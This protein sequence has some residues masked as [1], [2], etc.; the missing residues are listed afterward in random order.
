MLYNELYK[1]IISKE[2]SCD[3]LLVDTITNTVDEF[4]A[5]YEKAFRTIDVV[6]EAKAKE[7]V[8][9]FSKFLKTN[10]HLNIQCWEPNKEEYPA[11]MLLGADKGILAYLNFYYHEADYNTAI[12]YNLRRIVSQVKLVISDLDRPTFFVHV[13]YTPGI[14]GI[15]FETHEQ[16]IDRL[17]NEKESVV[18]KDKY[19]CQPKYMGDIKELVSIMTDLKKNNVNIY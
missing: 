14:K 8:T 16:I 7:I 15:Y 11:Y 9:I 17:L 10:F 12:G 2:N 13:V 4:Q 5:V 19:I 1:F 18:F 6:E 3:S